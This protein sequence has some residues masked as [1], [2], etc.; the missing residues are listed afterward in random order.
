MKNMRF[1]P[2]QC[3]TALALMM[4]TTPIWAQTLHSG[5]RSDDFT[6]I[7]RNMSPLGMVN[8]DPLTQIPVG[9]KCVDMPVTPTSSASPLI[10]ND[11][12]GFLNG[13]F[14][15]NYVGR[16]KIEYHG[17]AFQTADS[18][19][20][21]S[22]YFNDERVFHADFRVNYVVATSIPWVEL[23]SVTGN[24]TVSSYTYPN[25]GGN[26]IIVTPLDG[27]YVKSDW[28]F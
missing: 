15:L 20:Y 2:L 27:G 7:R 1:F 24:F 22:Y 8:C 3:I 25:S 11:Q 19:M 23:R 6:G 26:Q 4:L 16:V 12:G 14:F 28:E 18:S 9:S 17:N 5:E 13:L 21:T 10:L